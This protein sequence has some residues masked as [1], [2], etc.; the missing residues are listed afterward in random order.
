M[1]I[2]KTK[3]KAEVVQIISMK[4]LSFFTKVTDIILHKQDDSGDKKPRGTKLSTIKNT[5]LNEDCKKN[6]FEII[7]HKIKIFILASLGMCLNV[8]VCVC[9]CVCEGG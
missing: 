2:G 9:V 6:F 7:R 5:I 4:L 8:C 3:N 1:I